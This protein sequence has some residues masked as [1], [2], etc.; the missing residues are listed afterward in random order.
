M[1]KRPKP[2]VYRYGMLIMLLFLA[3][4]VYIH[5]Q[6]PSDQARSRLMSGINLYSQGRWG[7]AVSELRRVQAEAPSRELRGE[8][9]FW[10]GM[11]ELSAGEYEA[12]L[13]DMDALAATDPGSARLSELPYHRGRV[14]YYLGR[15]NEAIVLLK[16][17]ADYLGSKTGQTLSPAEIARRPAALYWTGECLFSMGQLDKAAELFRLVTDDY[18]GT[19]K[20][21]ASVYRLELIN[22]K[23]VEAEL[24]N[25]LKVSH[26]EALKNNEEFRRRE[27]SYDQALSAYQKRIAEMSQDTRLQDLEGSNATYQ[28]QLRVAQERIRSL[29]SSLK[30]TSTDLEKAKGATAL[31]RLRTLKASAQEL[32]ARIMG[33]DGSTRGAGK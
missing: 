6:T 19:A 9:L 29:E 26:E 8:A 12:A 23:K 30:E 15:Y 33:Q 28:E 5:A 17:Y 16:G 18:P 4:A 21:E 24:L 22:Q 3:G 1:K 10:I 7:E 13:A 31:E 25:L 14:L 11:A 27:T 32:E 2:V 20:Y